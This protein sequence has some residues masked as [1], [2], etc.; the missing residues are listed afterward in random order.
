MGERCLERGVLLCDLVRDLTVALSFDSSLKIRSKSAEVGWPVPI[1]AT[2]GCWAERV[3]G[4]VRWATGGAATSM[5]RSASS[6]RLS[7]GVVLGEA[8]KTI[9]TLLGRRCMNNSRRKLTSRPARSP[10]S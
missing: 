9:L 3:D 6:A 4:V 2:W 1:A 5:T 10:S 8:A 7:K